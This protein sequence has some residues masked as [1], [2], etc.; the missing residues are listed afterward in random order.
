MVADAFI[1]LQETYRIYVSQIIALSFHFGN[2]GLDVM[3]SEPVLLT[4]FTLYKRLLVN[5]SNAVIRFFKQI[6]FDNN[7]LKVTSE[8]LVQNMHDYLSLH[9]EVKNC[10][11]SNLDKSE[12]HFLIKPFGLTIYLRSSYK[13]YELEKDVSSYCYELC[14]FHKQDKDE[15]TTLTAY[16]T[17]DSYLVPDVMQPETICEVRNEN[18]GQ[19]V[20]ARILHNL[21]NSKIICL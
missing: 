3:F 1:A 20:F 11:V 4:V 14:F 5:K 6:E 15:V 19:K 17:G 2:S 16:I 7:A 21:Y 12:P 8:L 10:V 9:D 18:R 13:L